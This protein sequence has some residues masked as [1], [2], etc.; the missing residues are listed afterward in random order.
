[1][2]NQTVVAGASM[3]K[4]SLDEMS[5]YDSLP[6][7]VR[8]AIAG[9]PYKIRAGS[10]KVAIQCGRDPQS[11]VTAITLEMARLVKINAVPYI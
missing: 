11:M 6:A 7:L 1:M 3:R 10:I 9:A 2:K 8:Q 5:E 4:G